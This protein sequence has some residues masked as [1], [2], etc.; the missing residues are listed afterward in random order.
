MSGLI[1]RCQKFIDGEAIAPTRPIGMA[2]PAGRHDAHQEFSMESCAFRPICPVEFQDQVQPFLDDGRHGIPVEG[3]L[4]HD[5]A[6]LKEARLFRFHVD[7]EIGV[8]VIKVVYSDP[9]DGADRIEQSAL[10]DRSL[11][12]GMSKHDENFH[13]VWYR[14]V[15]S[16][17]KATA[18]TRDGET[19]GLSG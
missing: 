1:E 18:D 17:T 7:V 14:R 16:E 11:K 6:V 4:Q 8:G 13:L 9:G 10:D 2:I 5:K 12:A 19:W 15:L 3:M